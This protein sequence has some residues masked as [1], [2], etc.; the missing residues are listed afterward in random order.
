MIAQLWQPVENLEGFEQDIRSW[1]AQC[2]SAD[3]P[4]LLLHADDIVV[5]GHWQTDKNVR[6]SIDVFE[7][8]GGAAVIHPAT[9]QQCRIFGRSGE[10]LIWRE[11][12]QFR[13]RV[14]KD[15]HTTINDKDWFDEWHLLWGLPVKEQEGFS[16]LREGRQG[17]QHTVPIV[18]R[19]PQRAAIKVRHYIQPD[20]HG[21]AVIV[22][23]RLVDIGLYP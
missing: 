14:V 21:Q 9:V 5:W 16:L 1:L 17:Q 12:T 8:M 20:H 13:G 18:V 23:S 7:R 11:G 3:M 4:W 22:L 6:L 10:V 19:Y 15:I 2:M